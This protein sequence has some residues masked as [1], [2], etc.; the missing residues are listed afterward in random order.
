ML[1]GHH[2]IPIERVGGMSGAASPQQVLLWEILPMH[3]LCDKHGPGMG[4]PEN[5][6]LI[7][8]LSSP[9]NYPRRIVR[10]IINNSINAQAG[11]A[12]SS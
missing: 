9:L 1:V 8:I 5:R 12:Q 6:V 7:G 11:W 4:S 2:G 3:S 10:K